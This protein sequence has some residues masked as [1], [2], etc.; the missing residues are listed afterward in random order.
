[1]TQK[2]QTAIQKSRDIVNKMG[3]RHA[4]KKEM[5]SAFTCAQILVELE[6]LLEV[7]KQQIMQAAYDNM[8]NNFDPN[9]G[10]AE[11]CYNETF[12]QD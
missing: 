10:R 9:M 1:M 2:K 12:K 11:Q 7:E 5:D 4:A 3:V 6:E 8:G